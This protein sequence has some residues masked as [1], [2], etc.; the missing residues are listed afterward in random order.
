MKG[1]DK[2]ARFTKDFPKTNMNRVKSSVLGK[3]GTE[4]KK[5]VKKSVPSVKFTRKWKG[6]EVTFDSEDLKKKVTKLLRGRPGNKYVVVGMKTSKWSP[7]W[8]HW[9]EFGTLAFRGKPLK[10]GR[11][12]KAEDL[13]QRGMGLRKKPFMRRA[14][15]VGMPLVMGLVEEELGKKIEN[16]S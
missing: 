15:R 7:D 4:M 14:F 3:M 13:A 1:F 16:R 2:F 6:K 8:S 5:S 9:I 11:K 12:A 10:R